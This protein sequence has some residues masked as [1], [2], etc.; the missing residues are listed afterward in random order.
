[1]PKAWQV[2][3]DREVDEDGI[4]LCVAETS[5]SGAAA[6]APAE[7]PLQRHLQTNGGGGKAR[8][9]TLR[10]RGQGAP[11]VYRGEVER[12]PTLGWMAL[13]ASAASRSG[14]PLSLPTSAGSS[15]RYGV[16]TL[17][18][19]ARQITVTTVRHAAMVRR[20]G[21][22]TRKAA[23]V[24]SEADAASATPAAEDS[25]AADQRAAARD[26]L[27][28]VFGSKRAKKARSQARDGV[29]AA[30]T[31][32]TGTELG[33]TEQPPAAAVDTVLPS[34]ASVSSDAPT[35][36][37]HHHRREPPDTNSSP[38]PAEAEASAT[39]SLLPPHD[40]TALQPEQAFPLLGGCLP[41]AVFDDVRAGAPHVSQWARAMLADT[42]PFDASAA[43]ATCLPMEHEW[44]L[45][46]ALR[47]LAQRCAP[48]SPAS[49]TDGIAPPSIA[50]AAG[51][52][53]PPDV[54]WVE[55]RVAAAVYLRHLMVAYRQWPTP[56]HPDTFLR[57]RTAAPAPPTDGVPPPIVRAILSEFIADD[58]PTGPHRP[59][60]DRERL[61]HHLLVLHLHV[62]G[63]ER[64]PLNTLA[65]SL[66][67]TP[68]RCG[69]YYKYMGLTVRRGA[70]P[71][72]AP[73]PEGA[74]SHT[75]TR[76]ASGEFYASLETLPLRFP[77]PA[78]RKR[79]ARR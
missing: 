70:P 51:A 44:L 54:A 75:G 37:H 16:L 35:Q 74:R 46:E 55:Q 73:E 67:M 31:V 76:R 50:P 24:T 38:Q 58:G 30:S 34:A 21:G 6:P 57:D 23:T 78:Y 72:A 22:R 25:T 33:Q 63:F 71:T 40:R 7:G 14:L 79:L 8:R 77:K 69:T 43:V 1:M 41:V 52:P 12:A 28:A 11:R 29:L 3:H 61:L 10:V 42:S 66:G 17:D 53:S 18:P 19:V 47:L 13:G 48:S 20:G 68:T 64:A 26:A 15:A 49:V 9:V 4:V 27:V 39:V 45:V 62:V 2:V 65:V 60:L 32:R 5:A 56:L 36:P 59:H